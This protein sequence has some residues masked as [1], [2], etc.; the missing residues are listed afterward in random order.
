MAKKVSHTDFAAS[1]NN[2]TEMASIP[3]NRPASAVRITDAS[4]PPPIVEPMLPN[5]SNQVLGFHDTSGADCLA[6]W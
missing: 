3:T 1:R 4:A 5:Q 6:A 2:H